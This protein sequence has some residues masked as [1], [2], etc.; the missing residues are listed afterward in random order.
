MEEIVKEFNDKLEE[1]IP[2]YKFSLSTTTITL[3]RD[4]Y[5]KKSTEPDEERKSLYESLWVNNIIN[6]RK[7][8]FSDDYEKNKGKDTIK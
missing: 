3:L 2:D 1:L 6:I 4:L 7:N 8:I 5:I